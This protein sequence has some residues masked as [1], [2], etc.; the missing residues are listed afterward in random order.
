[1][2]PGASSVP[3]EDERPLGA[4]PLRELLFELE[5]QP[6]GPVE[7]PRAGEAGP[8]ALECVARPL[9][10]RRV[11]GEAEVVVGPEH[12][13]LGPFHLHHGSRGGLQDAEVGQ[14]IGLA[15]GRELLDPLVGPGLFED[16]DGYAHG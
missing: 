11:L 15:G 2:S 6:G 8:V 1:V 4:H 12:D 16:V 7:Q 5:V 14:Q 9:H 10:H 13:P 3:S